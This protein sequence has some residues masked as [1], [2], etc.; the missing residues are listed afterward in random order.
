MRNNKTQCQIQVPSRFAMYSLR[1]TVQALLVQM[2][3]IQ[4]LIIK[5]EEKDMGHDA[6]KNQS[7]ARVYMTAALMELDKML[8]AEEKEIMREYTWKT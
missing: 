6:H 4:T 1:R 8:L 5:L 7:M 2:E 3:S